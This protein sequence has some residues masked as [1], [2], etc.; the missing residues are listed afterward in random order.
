M[1]NKPLLRLA[2]GT[3]TSDYSATPWTTTG[4][5]V[6]KWLVVLHGVGSL[7]M[8]SEELADRLEEE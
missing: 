8:T 2:D 4:D 5:T 1:S 3:K 7:F 6:T